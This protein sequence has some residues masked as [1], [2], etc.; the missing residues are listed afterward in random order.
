MKNSSLISRYFF[1]SV[2]D[3]EFNKWANITLEAAL[4]FLHNRDGQKLHAEISPNEISN[5]FRTIEIPE[6]GENIP[7]V[8]KETIEKIV[9]NS[10]RV[11]HPNYIGH[12]T[13]ATPNFL[14]LCDIIISAL[15]QNVV[16]IETALSATYV[17]WQTL[18]WL[19]NLIYNK[20]KSFYNHILNNSD[21]AVGNYCSGGTVGNLTALV[22]ARN[23]LFPNI[24]KIGIYEAFKK[25]DCTRAVL[26]VSQRGH[27]SIKKT[28]AIM[29]IGEQNVI[30]I[31]C[32]IFT[33]KINVP[34]L[35]NTIQ[36]LLHEKTKI[37]SIIGVAGTTETGNI[38]DLKKLSQ[39]CTKHK[40]WFHVD[41]AW[42]GALLLSSK[43]KK[44]L[45]GIENADSVV[46]DGHKFLYLTMSHGAVLFKNEHSLDTIR[47]TAKY[48][49]R[50]SSVDLGRTTIEGS[51]R[52]DSLKLWFCFKAIGRQGYQTL[53][54]KAI[55][56][57]FLLSQMAESHQS[58]EATNKPETSILTYRYLPKSLK[59][60]I[61]I[62]YDIWN[63]KNKDKLEKIKIHFPKIKNNF[64][65]VIRQLNL[66]LNEININIQKKQ[67]KDGKS[68]VS[69][70]TL[71][72]IWKS[73][74]IVVLRAVP[75]HPLTN[76]ETFTE[77]LTEQEIL[78]DFFFNNEKE[79][80]F[81]KTPDAFCLFNDF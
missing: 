59:I 7:T 13:G 11:S 26:L 37:I 12:M 18:C 42:G 69:R 10:V 35:E 70:T 55:E 2:K 4:N 27:Y 65:L 71:E 76:Q 81:K 28:A 39:I 48:I 68:F 41:A 67:R 80:F 44:R 53:I 25:A 77:I 34:E 63:L 20:E 30:T 23:I 21:I 78:G 72:S 19:H 79:N 57:A 1:P 49:I 33:N 38:D 15:N 36:K 17:E 24:H 40:I 8:L 52:F 32:D 51:R 64:D 22:T 43:H 31:P 46:I 45:E 47:H 66:F 6:R 9:K 62:I 73:Q 50:E 3:K 14:L 56:N 61:K 75:F 5:F 58:F 29:G 16:K 74:E 60:Q 54:D